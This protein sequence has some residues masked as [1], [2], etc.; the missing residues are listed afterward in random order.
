MTSKGRRCDV[1]TSHRRRYDVMYLLGICPPPPQYSKPWPP[2]ILNLPTPIYLECLAVVHTTK[3]V[4][5]GFFFHFFLPR[6]LTTS[7]GPGKC[8]FIRKH[9]CFLNLIQ[10]QRDVWSFQSE[11]YWAAEGETVTFIPFQVHH[12]SEKDHVDYIERT[13]KLLNAAEVGNDSYLRFIY[14]NLQHDILR[15]AC[16]L[17]SWK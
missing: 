10:S 2:I 7:L 16:F 5:H 15:N 4:I 14:C 8:N 13:M 1:I 9:V 11:V 3:A 17:E 6:V 12:I